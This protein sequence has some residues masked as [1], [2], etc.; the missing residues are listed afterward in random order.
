MP[1]L[2]RQVSGLGW[3][4]ARYGPLVS[5]PQ[6][7]CEQI[8]TDRGLR[9]DLYGFVDSL[10]LVRK[11]QEYPGIYTFRSKQNS[12]FLETATCRKRKCSFNIN[13]NLNASNHPRWRRLK[14][15]SPKKHSSEISIYFMSGRCICIHGIQSNKPDT[16]FWPSSCHCSSNEYTTQRARF[17]PK[18]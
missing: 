11:G 12:S 18:G 6:I 5:P 2:P 8:S 14:Y 1:V 9:V 7:S 17:G 4:A 13:I 3:N 15:P 16:S 10:S